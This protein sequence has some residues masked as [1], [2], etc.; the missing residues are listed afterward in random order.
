[1][2]AY[3]G[4]NPVS[5]KDSEGKFWNFVIGGI[6]GAIV[7]GVTAAVSSY[8]E[9]GKINGASVLLGAATGAVGGLIGASGISVVG[10]AVASG[11]ISAANNVGNS[12]IANE[13]VDWADVAV[14][15]TIGAVSSL[16]GSAVTAKASAAAKNTIKKVSI[17]LFQERSGMIAV[18]DTGRGL[19][20]EAW[21]QFLKELVN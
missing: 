5:R 10:Q 18:H 17:V 6:V 3:C 8:K 7:G 21:K 13:E 2:F 15:A 12:L 14:D 1:M 19:L 20:N 11:V 16:V 9:T 4:N